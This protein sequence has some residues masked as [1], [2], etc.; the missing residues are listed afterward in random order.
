MASDS[1]QRSIELTQHFTN[2]ASNYHSDSLFQSSSYQQWLNQITF[3]A[4]DLKRNHTV[5]D[6]G[7][8]PGEDTLWL[9][10]KMNKEINLIASDISSGMIKI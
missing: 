4:L 5:V 8:G 3:N 6:L 1:N 10:S 9:S 2:V 7:C